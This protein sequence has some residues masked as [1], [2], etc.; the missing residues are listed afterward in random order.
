MI[1]LFTSEIVRI[2]AA[3]AEEAIT[4]KR[5]RNPRI[6]SERN[7]RETKS[8][9]RSDIFIIR[10]RSLSTEASIRNI[11]IRTILK[12][13]TRR[14]PI[15]WPL[16]TNHKISRYSD[17]HVASAC[18]FEVSWSNEERE[19]WSW[20][21]EAL[22]RVRSLPVRWGGGGGEKNASGVIDRYSTAVE[23]NDV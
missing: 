12:I 7:E 16:E 22:Q 14:P 10:K 9:L 13:A 15:Q 3:R 1:L 21:E 19:K 6:I 11:H 23:I 20:N 17:I 4:S 18:R 5:N 2:F 8:S